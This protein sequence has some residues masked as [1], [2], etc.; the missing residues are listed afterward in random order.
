MY[1]QRSPAEIQTRTQR[2]LIG[3]TM[4][5]PALCYRPAVFF[6]HLRFDAPLLP[7]GKIR[8]AFQNFHTF[9]FIFQI[10]KCHKPDIQ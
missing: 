8:R 1:T 2:N 7:K 10:S 4:S 5:A 6:H 3:R 9:H